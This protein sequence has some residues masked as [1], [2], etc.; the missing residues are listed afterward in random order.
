MYRDM[1]LGLAHDG[2]AGHIGVTK[3]FDYAKLF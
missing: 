3:T 1:I 2:S